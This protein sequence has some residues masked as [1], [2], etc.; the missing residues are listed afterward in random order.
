MIISDGYNG[1]PSGFENTCEDE[2]GN[3]K[4]YVLHARNRAILKVARSPH[5][6]RCYLVPCYPLQ[7][8]VSSFTSQA[9]QESFLDEYK[10]PLAWIFEKSQCRTLTLRGC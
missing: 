9:F 5:S 2:E 3:T 8:A 7:K 10:I 6:V 4:W 1:C